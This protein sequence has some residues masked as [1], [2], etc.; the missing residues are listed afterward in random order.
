MQIFMR[1]LFGWDV[2]IGIVIFLVS[3]WVFYAEAT[4]MMLGV[5]VGATLLPDLISFPI[6]LCIKKFWDPSVLTHRQYSHYP[7]I[8]VPFMGGVAYLYAPAVGL[9][10]V[11]TSAVMCVG[12]SAHFLHDAME[13]QGYPI[14]L[15]FRKERY[16][17]SLPFKITFVS[18]YV[19]NRRIEELAEHSGNEFQKRKESVPPLWVYAPALSAALYM[20]L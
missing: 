8:F 12:N 14:F 6:F 15:P 7:V 18:S 11:H 20:V 2:L 19:Y 9:D 4:W 16:R 17:F 13:T 1:I 3:T 5:S 10:A